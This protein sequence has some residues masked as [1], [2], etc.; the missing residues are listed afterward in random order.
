MARIYTTLNQYYV[1]L[2]VDPGYQLGPN[3]L[4][5][6]YA[7]SASGTMVPLSQ[8]A[9]MN[10]SI[11]PLAVNH[12]GQFPSVTLSFNLAPKST[13]GEVVSVIRRTAA[14][15]H[16]PAS[17]ATSFQGNAQA[18]Q[19]SLSSTPILILAALVAVYLILGMLYEST[20][21][22]LTIISTLP[23]AGLG[24]LLTLMLFGMPLDVIGIIGIILL[25][26]IVKKNGIMLVDFALVGQRERGLSSED[27]I[28]EA[29]RLRFRPIL[30]TTL[31]A[32]LAGVPLMLG[33]G[34]GSEIRQPLGYAIVGGLLV[35]QLLTLFTT[36]V[37]Y[38]YMDRIS[39]W[40]YSRSR[41]QSPD[42]ARTSN[43]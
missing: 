18:F 28:H 24:A 29:C 26:G 39:G 11:A 9:S 40:L 25:I 31:C 33:T 1:I 21:H 6:I 12:Q 7:Q 30:M 19:N 23:S 35:S 27:A 8:F 34:T 36:P 5:R 17:I 3:A 2:E 10:R 43:P 32:L 16:M 38:I 37:V 14:D 15:L 41:P 42:I 13:I 22:P 20:I 4:S